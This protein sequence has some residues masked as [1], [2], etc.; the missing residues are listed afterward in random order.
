L[1]N[2]RQLTTPT[3]LVLAAII[4]CGQS[5]PPDPAAATYGGPV[6]TRE[7]RLPV[8]VGIAGGRREPV[9][10]LIAARARARDLR[11]QHPG[12]TIEI[13]LPPGIT[14][15]TEPLAIDVE[16]SG[17]PE[18]PLRIRGTSNGTSTLSGGVIAAKAQAG[19]TFEIDLAAILG[20][21]LRLGSTTFGMSAATGVPQIYQ[22]GWKIGLSAWPREGYL[23]GWTLVPSEGGMLLRWPEGSKPPDMAASVLVSGYLLADWAYEV[24]RAVPRREGLFL[25]GYTPAFDGK[26]KPHVR[27]LNL[28]AVPE[29][30]RM[31][32][33]E[34][35]GRGIVRTITAGTV[36]I[37]RA[38][39]LLVVDHAHNV[40]ISA[41]RFEKTV[42]AAVRVIG[43]HDVTF[44]QCSIGQTGSEGMVLTNSTNILVEGC[45]LRAI[46]GSGISVSA[47]NRTTLSPG[48]V[49]IRDTVIEQFGTERRNYQ[50]AVSLSG[51]G[52]RLEHSFIAA[53]PHLAVGLSGNDLSVTGTEIAAVACE[54]EDVGAIYMGRDWTMRGLR[55]VG[56][57][58]HDLGGTARLDSHPVG[59]YLDD[60]FS[61][62]TIS[63]NV[64]LRMGWGVLIGGGRDNRVDGNVFALMR[65]AAI[66]YDARGL[67]HQSGQVTPGGPFMTK[68]EQ[69]PYRTQLWTA[70]YPTLRSLSQDHPGAPVGNAAW[71][72]VLVGSVWLEGYHAGF[73]L[74][75]EPGK[76]RPVPLELADLSSEEAY[77]IL[78][79]LAGLH[80]ERPGPRGQLLYDR[81]R[82]SAP[83]CADAAP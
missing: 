31:K 35:S 25:P 62:V 48:R 3:C 69:S 10:S 45:V 58:V 51:V 23:T 75:G 70:R 7:A 20:K 74:A 13:I 54:T 77:N 41:I 73:P 42:G 36:E 82:L 43:S 1:R 78:T 14:R 76:A 49:V 40:A 47:G 46:G 68:L 24:V 32:L 11:R 57:F 60:Q 38:P 28:T 30:G 17:T 22:G 39:S 81:F 53:A 59:V 2:L 66:H 4:T 83:S 33:D 26:G 8:R 29:A 65:T 44:S 16:D 18:A 56:N 50:P 80:G 37:A 9:A 79:R 67:R 55:I 19:K 27:V 61:G 52:N 12:R 21:P 64:F 34:D 5:P 15:L 72:N 6:A 71:N 63:R